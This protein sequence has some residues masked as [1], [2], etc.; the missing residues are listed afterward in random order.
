MKEHPTGKGEEEGK[1]GRLNHF[2]WVAASFSIVRG[3][4][5]EGM[6]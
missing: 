3:R 6:A 4:A 2:H 5:D 1:F